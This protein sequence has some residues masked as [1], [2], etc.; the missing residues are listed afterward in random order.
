[1]R[2]VV[3]RCSGG[4]HAVQTVFDFDLSDVGWM[5]RGVAREGVQLA[6]RRLPENEEDRDGLTLGSSLRPDP[7]SL[8]VCPPAARGG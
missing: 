6:L 5:G 4:G 3:H 8:S 1:M 7:V 2:I